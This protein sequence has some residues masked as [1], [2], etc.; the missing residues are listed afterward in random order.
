MAGTGHCLS[1]A[2]RRKPASTVPPEGGRSHPS[3]APAGA[4]AVGPG[5]RLSLDGRACVTSLSDAAGSQAAARSPGRVRPASSSGPG[6]PAARTATGPPRSESV[7]YVSVRAISPV[8]QTPIMRA[9][10]GGSAA[11]GRT[12]DSGGTLARYQLRAGVSE[13]FA[14]SSAI[15]WR[16]SGCCAQLRKLAQSSLV[17]Q[18]SAIPAN[19]NS[20]RYLDF[21]RCRHFRRMVAGWPTDSA[22]RWSTLPGAR[23]ASP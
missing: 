12:H 19:W 14:S 9:C 20:S 23:E 2:A 18:R 16:A 15:I 5:R 11:G 22:T 8:L 1:C 13:P 4:R 10:T 6:R 17:S 21:S 7:I 3:K